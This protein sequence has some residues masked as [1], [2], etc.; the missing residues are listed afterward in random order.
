MLHVQQI[1]LLCSFQTILLEYTQILG[2][3]QAVGVVFNSTHWLILA[4]IFP[5]K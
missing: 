4:G 5:F 3:P 1:L 2:D